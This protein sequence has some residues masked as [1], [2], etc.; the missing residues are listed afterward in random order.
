MKHKKILPVICCFFMFFGYSCALQKIM[1]RQEYDKNLDLSKRKEI[2]EE[3]KLTLQPV[4][5]GQKIKI[6]NSEIMYEPEQATVFF[7]T[8]SPE[9]Y[10]FYEK[11]NSEKDWAT[12]CNTLAILEF[13]YTPIFYQID[14]KM[15]YNSLTAGG[16][17]LIAGII[18]SII[19]H[20][21]L[22][23]AVASY[24]EGL[25]KDLGLTKNNISFNVN[26]SNSANMNIVYKF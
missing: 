4:F 25:L 22:N 8:S 24:N 9:A 20:Q 15:A 5:L 12:V 19:H 18:L 7:L 17:L 1:I 13:A 26:D 14:K 2:Y 6:G 16:V 21:S 11:A 23:N 10:A 3:K